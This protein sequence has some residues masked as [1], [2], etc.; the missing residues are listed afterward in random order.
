MK[1]FH[2]V[3]RLWKFLKSYGRRIFL[4][5]ST[6]AREMRVPY[7]TIRRWLARLREDG[8]I[9]IHQRG[10]TSSLY[11]LL[12]PPNEQAFEQA[13]EQARAS[14]PLV[15]K[16]LSE[17]ESPRRKPP[18]S[19][20][21][22]VTRPMDGFERFFGLFLA[23][24]KP[25]NE[26]NMIQAQARWSCLTPQD[27][28]CAIADAERQLIRTK[29]TRFMPFPENYLAARPW[30]RTAPSRTLPYIDPKTDKALQTHD[31]VLRLLKERGVA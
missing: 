29:E 17:E 15:S 10:P 18:C 21:G 16:I 24:G 31:E 26:G 20:G 14:Y 6:M 22:F 27:K 12:K 28:A 19:E 25:M 11:V 3:M 7:P 4:K 1:L 8:C 2:G 23:A 9:E 30:N 13:F 5:Q